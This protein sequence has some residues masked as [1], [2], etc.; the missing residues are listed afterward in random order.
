MRI[1]HVNA[2][3]QGMKLITFLA[4]RLEGSVPRGELHRWIRTG[5]VRVNKGRA[6]AFAPLATGDAVRLPPFAPSPAEK[7]Y[8][9]LAVNPGDDLGYGVTV[10]AAR[11]DFLAL[12]K[13]PDLPTQPGTGHIVSLVSVLREYFAKAAHVPAPA[14]RLDAATGGIVLAGGT[15][16]AQ[17]ELHALFAARGGGIEKTYLAW[18][19]GNWPH[20]GETVLEDLLA[21]E[22]AVTLS[23]AL[24][25]SV[26]T[27]DAGGCGKKAVCRVT[28]LAQRCGNT[29][30]RIVL[31]TG[32]THQ[33]RVQ[34]ASRAHPILGDVK[35]GGPA[36][37]RLLLHA[38][39]LVFA[40]KGET[41]TLLSRPRWD[42]PFAVTPEV[43]QFD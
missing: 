9:E 1:L 38:A 33:I 37:P 43:C 28:P 14:H 5:Q 21:K 4:K 27:G 8:M 11:G 10:L 22:T 2:A 23:G 31:E 20:E 41:V 26:A 18:A 24:F 25:E 7:E 40:W 29:L 19:A 17:R 34:L 35:Y 32:R 15:H 12:E 39:K 6:K 3:E 36:R 42:T 16:A 30:L 13:P